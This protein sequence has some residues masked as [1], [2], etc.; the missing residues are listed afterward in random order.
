MEIKVLNHRVRDNLFILSSDLYS[1]ISKEGY[2]L[3]D[4]LNVLDNTAEIL[5][6]EYLNPNTVMVP[7]RVYFDKKIDKALADM[8]WFA[9]V[10]FEN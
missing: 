6:D 8:K 5:E 7:D 4:R 1:K 3:P 2:T 9:E 10:Y